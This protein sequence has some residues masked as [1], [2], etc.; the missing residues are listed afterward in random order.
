MARPD[1]A[2]WLAKHGD[3]LAAMLDRPAQGS[4]AKALWDVVAAL[5]VKPLGL[6][7]TNDQML[8]FWRHFVAIR[9]EATLDRDRDRERA[10]DQLRA[11][12]FRANAPDP[13]ELFGTLELVA[14]TLNVRGAGLDVDQLRKHLAERYDIHLEPVDLQLEPIARTARDAAARDAQA[15]RDALKV[16]ALAPEFVP[17]DPIEYDASKPAKPVMGT[18]YKLD[19]IEPML[20]GHRG[21]AVEGVPGA[22]KTQSLVQIAQHLLDESELIP[23]VRSLP[24]LA[25]GRLAILDGIA[26]DPFHTI[27]RDGLALLA[28]TGRLVLLLDGWNELGTVAR[29]WA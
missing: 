2:K 25:L 1:S 16:A 23:I 10:I 18:A 5:S 9:I 26:T 20:R 13:A 12:T 24:S 7:P 17:L 22:G 19:G 27:G 3:A 11:V 14:G 29:D 15:W 6:A 21:L 4:D 28:R 8:R